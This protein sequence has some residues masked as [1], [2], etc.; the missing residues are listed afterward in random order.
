RSYD[1]LDVLSVPSGAREHAADNEC[2]LVARA[3]R[4]IMRAEQRGD[5]ELAD[6]AGKFV[7]GNLRGLAVTHPLHYLA[8]LMHR[9][10]HHALGAQTVAADA[11]FDDHL[12]AHELSVTVL[13]PLRVLDHRAL[14]GLVEIA[15]IELVRA[16]L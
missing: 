11:Q 10:R 16:R 5:S 13:L 12:S 1:M 15:P 8:G 7:P 3:L 2:A 9:R 4:R 6:R 14:L